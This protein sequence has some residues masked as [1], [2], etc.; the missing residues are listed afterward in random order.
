MYVVGEEP[1]ENYLARLKHYGITPGDA[2]L[3]GETSF[4]QDVEAGIERYKPHLVVVDSLQSL[5][6]HKAQSRTPLVEQNIMDRLIKLTRKH[7]VASV[8]IG[9]Y[10]KNGDVRGGLGIQHDVDAVVKIARDQDL[11]QERIISVEKNRSGPNGVTLRYVLSQ[12]ELK[13]M[14]DR[15]NGLGADLARARRRMQKDFEE[16]EDD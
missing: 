9:H 8:V 5:K 11:P 16:A 14:E 13:L 2:C 3:I 4:I 15:L 6:F 10:T 1:K 12:T 7:Q